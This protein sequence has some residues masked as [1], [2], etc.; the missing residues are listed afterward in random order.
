M[1]ALGEDAVAE[2][3]AL[4]P[5]LAQMDSFRLTPARVL[6]KGREGR[7]MVARHMKNAVDLFAA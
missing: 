2:I 6:V 7:N 4:F 5:D 3:L 1:K